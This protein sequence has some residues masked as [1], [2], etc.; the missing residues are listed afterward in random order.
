MANKLDDAALK[1]MVDRL[2]NAHGENLVS[3][4]LYGSAA[5]GEVADWRTDY[6]L[7]VALNY[8]APGD[9]RASQGP[10]REWTRA[11]HALPVYFTAEE[12]N[13][14]ADVF[15]I[16]F[17]RMAVARKVLF[18]P[19][20]FIGLEPSQVYLRHQTEYELR[21]KLIQLRRLYIPAAGSAKKLSDLMCQ[22]LLSFAD[23]FR[24][25]LVLFG[26]EA[27]PSQS[28]SVQR[29]AELLQLDAT[30]FE[31]L[32][33]LCGQEGESTL[34]ETEADEL[35]AS[36]LQQIEAVINAVDHLAMA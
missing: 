23:L 25:V 8:I 15:P 24:A 14:A 31:R 19:D 21:S 12:L 17:Q 11:G 6:H 34:S 4:V 35:F 27:P 18:G 5:L 36:Y 13:D 26:E 22:S 30:P 32:L 29:T 16:E 1:A 3:V 7:L 10:S 28:E 9:L 33:K 20:P 2:H